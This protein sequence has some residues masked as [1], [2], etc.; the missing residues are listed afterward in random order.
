MAGYQN[1]E[2][3]KIGDTEIFK[4]IKLMTKYEIR[5]EDI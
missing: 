4:L 1:N 3:A 5:I 2:T